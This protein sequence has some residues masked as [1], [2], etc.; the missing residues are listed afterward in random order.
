MQS[1]EWFVLYILIGVVLNFVGPLATRVRDEVAKD[2]RKGDSEKLVDAILHRNPVPEWK[3]V[4]FEVTLRGLTLVAFPLLICV[5]LIDKVRSG[6]P[7]DDKS[8][9]R[10]FDPKLYFWKM[11]G[12][13][14]VFCRGCDFRQPLVSF[15][16][17]H[18]DAPEEATETGFQCQDCGTFLQITNDMNN[19]KGRRCNCGGPLSSEEPLFCPE[20]RSLEMAYKMSFIT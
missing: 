11:G 5:I 7:D 14:E 16:H 19:T 2:R 10:E 18:G 9:E 3:L 12:A 8:T 6:R 1:M 15:L 20:C 13:G 4:A 17:G